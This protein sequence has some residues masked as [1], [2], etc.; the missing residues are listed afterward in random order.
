[1]MHQSAQQYAVKAFI[2]KGQV[3][4]VALQK[5]DAGIFGASQ[6]DE[7]RTEIEA[8]GMIALPA[9]KIG[10]HA[11]AAT[12]IGDARAG[13]QPCQSHAC[14]HQPKVAF[15]G[16][17]II[18]IH[19]GMTVEEC[20]L[21]LLVLRKQRHSRNPL[22]PSSPINR[23]MPYHPV[24]AGISSRV[25]ASDARCSSMAAIVG[26]RRRARGTHQTDCLI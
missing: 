8:G 2:W 4:D 3:F 16:E 1:M 18:G 13:L 10:E 23:S 7:L 15:G 19:G 14:R 25:Q 20:D 22:R 24:F 6:G 11:R 26:Q 17:D 9:Q 12:E 5:L 21:L